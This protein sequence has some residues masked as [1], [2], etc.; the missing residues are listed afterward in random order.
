MT[1]RP[2]ASLRT[3]LA[4]DLTGGLAAAI[5][6]LPLALAF[7]IAAGA[8]PVTGIITAVVA[9]IVAALFGGCPVQITGP[10][11]AMTVILAS[12][13]AQ[14][15]LETVALATLLAGLIQVGLALARVGRL[16]E[17]LPLPVVS[18]FT[19]GIAV[20]IAG[21]QLG[22]FLGIPGPAGH[23]GFLATIGYL[24]GH[25]DQVQGASL[26][27][28]LAT[29][30]L[31]ALWTRWPAASRFVPGSLLALV[32]V[33]GASV[34]LGL[35]VATIGAIPRTLP[36]L[37]LPALDWGS[38]QAMI[39]PAVALAALGAIEAL[40]SAVV[41][42]GMTLAQHSD[43]DK[44]LRGQGLGNIAV[45]L[46]GGITATGAIARTAVNV[47]S[48]GKTRLSGVLHG[49]FL[50]LIVLAGAPL[51]SRIPLAVLAGILMVTSWRMLAW[52]EIH[53][54]SRSTRADFLVMLVTFVTTVAFDLVL[55]VEVGIL[56]ASGMFIRRAI[57]VPIQSSP[58]SDEAPA[59][60][61]PG[62]A[63]YRIDGPLFFGAAHRFSHTVNELGDIRIVIFRMRAVA[64]ID[65]TAAVSLDD[66][67][68]LLA[69]HGVTLILT[70]LQPAVA[71]VLTRTGMVAR[72]GPRH[73][74]AR[75][76]Q[77]LAD[78]W[79]RQAA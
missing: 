67:R 15:G 45:A 61:P 11:G 72:L 7:A 46:C 52:E 35:P 51:A 3:T 49:V 76:D 56:V 78:L 79:Q 4:G 17:L 9:G 31:K 36:A 24:L 18:G 19:S 2:R 32:L 41:A 59:P 21:G 68:A 53:L 26:G 57:G 62:V 48:G 25:L 16:V 65:V 12:I 22:P 60:V 29:I 13:V 64:S 27:V 14:H 8:P 28:G 1:G 54:I 42:D 73:I 77:A 10:T 5:V 38:I 44:E 30:G 70:G 37:R 23:Q 74:Y 40:L 58:G 66:M 20:I 50:L 33:T 71:A 75:T 6:A 69:R 63:V 39:Q 34:A 43:P 47:R 55:A